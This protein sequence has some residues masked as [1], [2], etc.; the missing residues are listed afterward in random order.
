MQFPKACGCISQWKGE[1]ERGGG[2]K[3]GEKEGKR[4]GMKEEKEGRTNSGPS[5]PNMTTS[6]CVLS[7]SDSVTIFVPSPNPLKGLYVCQLKLNPLAQI[8]ESLLWVCGMCVHP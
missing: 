7:Y 1:K 6:F 3:E 4:Q 8:H 2:M 5:S